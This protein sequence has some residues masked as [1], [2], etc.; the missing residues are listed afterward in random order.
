MEEEEESHTAVEEATATAADEVEAEDTT[1]LTQT[2]ILIEDC[3][4]LLVPACLTTA[5]SRQQTRQ[6][7]RGRNLSNTLAQITDNTE[8]IHYKI[9]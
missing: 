4:T 8:V 6:D 7:H 9:N 5:R 3:A 2:A 1:T